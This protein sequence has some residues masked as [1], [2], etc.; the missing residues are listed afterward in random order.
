[1]R[2]DKR[3]ILNRV[4]WG[5]LIILVT[6]GWV[7]S[8]AVAQNEQ[9][10]RGGTLKM[11]YNEPP[12]LNPALITGPP[13][14]L[15]ALQIFA[16]LLQFD[17][18]YQPRPYLAK[19]WEISPDG[20]RYTFHLEKGATFHDGKPITSADVAFSLEMIRKNHPFGELT[21]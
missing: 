9:T 17:E 16:G 14:G 11:V 8:S 10:P 21:F 1:M 15:P 19:K 3:L 5:I 13:T 18:N 7:S 4:L 20:C 12:H 2:V 6:I